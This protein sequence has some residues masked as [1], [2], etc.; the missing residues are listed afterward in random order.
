MKKTILFLMLV[1]SGL[2]YGQVSIFAALQSNDRSV[3]EG[4]IRANPKHPRVPEL[5]KK[6]QNMGYTSTEA[7][8]TTSKLTASKFEKNINNA[9]SSENAKKTAALLTNLLNDNKYS[10]DAILQIVNKSDCELVIKVNGKKKF[11]NLSVP[12]KN[13]NYV[14]VDKGSYTLTS[15]ICGVSYTSNKNISMNLVLTLGNK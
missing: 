4:F 11:Y 3:V 15:S 14:L 6:L 13:Q 7:R 9:N 1:V 2:Y 8:P 10:K 5:T 12:A